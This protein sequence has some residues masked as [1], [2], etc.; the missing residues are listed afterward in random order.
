MGATGIEEGQRVRG[1]A[2]TNKLVPTLVRTVLAEAIEL[3]EF[4]H[5][6]S[7]C[8]HFYLS[9]LIGARIGMATCWVSAPRHVTSAER[10]R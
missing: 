10:R 1:K 3:Y 2:G 7:I 9:V 4:Y 5:K 8:S 6:R